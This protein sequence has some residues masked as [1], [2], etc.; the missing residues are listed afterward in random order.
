L[1]DL[2][3][4]RALYKEIAHQKDVVLLEDDFSPGDLQRLYAEC[5]ILVGT[6]M[7]ANSLAMCVNTPVVA[8]AYQPKTT[9]IM[10]VMGLDD[11]VLAIDDVS[12]LVA[13][14]R[15]LWTQA[16]EVRE[17]LPRKVEV[18]RT[19]AIAAALELRAVVGSERQMQTT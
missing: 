18:L 10:A 13:R 16:D 8:I 6:R 17:M 19:E 1:E 14:A 11:W 9:G 5:R 12:E 7:H 4:G 3:A 15:D 2:K